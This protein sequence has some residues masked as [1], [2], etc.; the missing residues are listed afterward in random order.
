MGNLWTYIS[1][2]NGGRKSQIDYNTGKQKMEKF[3]TSQRISS[4]FSSVGSDHIVLVAK[5]RL[6]Y[7]AP[8]KKPKKKQYD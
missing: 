8:K 5:I 4:G 1:D 7:R 2:M 6:S 3:C